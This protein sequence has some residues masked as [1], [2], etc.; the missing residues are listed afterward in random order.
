[1]LKLLWLWLSPLRAR[2]ASLRK[3]PCP[4]RFSKPSRRRI[5]VAPPVEVPEARIESSP[6]SVSIASA[7]AVE[8]AGVI[9]FPV[10]VEY[11]DRTELFVRITTGPE[12]QP[13]GP[14]SQ[15]ERT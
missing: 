5:S 7:S 11:P 6:T 2:L 12:I 14:E 1:M 15:G 4:P 10:T 13:N 3:L 8:D 9:D